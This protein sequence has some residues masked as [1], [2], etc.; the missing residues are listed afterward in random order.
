MKRHSTVFAMVA[1]LAGSGYQS[2]CA[3]ET[4][5]Y[6]LVIK[7]HRFEPNVLHVPANQKFKLVVD[8]QDATSE[9]FE[10]PALKLEKVIAGKQRATLNVGPLQPGSYDFIGE[11]HEKTAKGR[12]VAQ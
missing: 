3:Q 12:F 1:L 11:F 2:V 6:Q 7:D 5:I 9:E 4:N 10:S 8:N